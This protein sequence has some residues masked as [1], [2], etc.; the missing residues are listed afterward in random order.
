M[1]VFN[2]A[3]F[4]PLPKNTVYPFAPGTNQGGQVFLMQGQI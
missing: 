2:Q 4:I 3:L 1:P